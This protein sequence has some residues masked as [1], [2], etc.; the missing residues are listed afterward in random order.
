MPR[1]TPLKIKLPRDKAIC[2]RH[3]L[4]ELCKLAETDGL[5]IGA[6]ARDHLGIRQQSLHC[7]LLDAREDRDFVVPAI[8]VPVISRLTMIPPFYFNPVLWPNPKWKFK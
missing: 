1:F 4:L 6:I 5:S 2:L 3:P 7:L 8:H